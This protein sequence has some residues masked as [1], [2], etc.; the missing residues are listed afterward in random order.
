MK[1]ATIRAEPAPT[2][3]LPEAIQALELSVSELGARFSRDLAQVLKAAVAT[4]NSMARL[5]EEERLLV[6]LPEA[7]RLLGGIGVRTLYDLIRHSRGQ[8]RIVK[9]GSRSFLRV[10]DLRDFVDS[11]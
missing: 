4:G 5:S 8:L 2:P 6:D 3:T 1:L 7:A 11:L 10:K 9:V